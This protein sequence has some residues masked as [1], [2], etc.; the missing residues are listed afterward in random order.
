MIW[1]EILTGY[2]INW[3][4]CWI[5]NIFF[6][7]IK[8]QNKK[9]EVLK[10]FEPVWK[11]ENPQDLSQE[12]LQSKPWRWNVPS[13]T[14]L[15]SVGYCCLGDFVSKAPPESPMFTGPAFFCHRYQLTCNLRLSCSLGPYL[16]CGSLLCTYVF[17]YEW[18]CKWRTNKDLISLVILGKHV[19][20]D[21]KETPGSQLFIS[22][23]RKL[24]ASEPQVFSLK[25]RSHLVTELPLKTRLS[26]SVR[27]SEWTFSRSGYCLSYVFVFIRRFFRNRA[28][29]SS[30]SWLL[31][32]SA[33][34]VRWLSSS[35]PRKPWKVGRTLAPSEYS[36]LSTG[37]VQRTEQRNRT[38][39]P[40][41]RETVRYFFF[42][43][44]NKW[45]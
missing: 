44:L 11:K 26:N 33:S 9:E 12:S 45:E 24:K 35:R 40:G 4:G 21:L 25:F 29:N 10:T 36:E 8:K 30:T 42:F 38:A 23:V 3:S 32:P 1:E 7:T 39:S 37:S 28:R 5:S 43:F 17:V 18:K 2:S 13:G 16:H 34:P 14:A 15:W 19:R 41:P 6:N 31:S 22:H 27:Q 20:R